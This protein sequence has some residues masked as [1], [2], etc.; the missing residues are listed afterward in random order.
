MKRTAITNG[1]GRW[2][3]AD[4]AECWHGSYHRDATDREDLYRTA[5]GKW[6]SNHWN[7]FTGTTE[8][9]TVVSR[10]YAAE[11]FVANEYDD[12]PDELADLVASLET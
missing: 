10:E 1:G 9:Y 3:D 6:V 5:S 7:R 8:T 11:W 12:L 4:K 2:F